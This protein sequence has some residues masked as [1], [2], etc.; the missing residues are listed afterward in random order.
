MKKILLFVIILFLF[1]ACG[2]N[3][4]DR[5]IA[6]YEDATEELLSA[7]SREEAL[8]VNRKLNSDYSA[9]LRENG[10]EFTELRRRALE[11]DKKIAL[12]FEKVNEIKRLYKDTKRKKFKEFNEGK[13]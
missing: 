2:G 4:Y 3:V 9:L 8:V 6:M 12:Q 7:K 1:S 13:R 5:T 10:D 11:G